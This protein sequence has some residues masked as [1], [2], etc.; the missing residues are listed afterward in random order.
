MKSFLSP[1]LAASPADFE[2]RN[3]RTGAILAS[4]LHTAF[5]SR[6]RNIGLLRHTTLPAMSALIIA[7]TTAIHTWFMK[8][9]IDVAFV[10]R[11]GEVVKA[12]HHLRPWRMSAVWRGFAVVEMPVGA[13]ARSSTQRGDRLEVVQRRD[14]S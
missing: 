13:L 2:L 7:P 5:D 4:E 6:S 9:P 10:A 3:L 14:R 8:F 12:R 11:S 1:L